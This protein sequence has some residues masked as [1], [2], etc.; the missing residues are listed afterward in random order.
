MKPKP[1][2]INT[3]PLSCMAFWFAVEEV[4]MENGCLWV[5][6]GSH[7]GCRAAFNLEIPQMKSQRVL[8]PV[9]RGTKKQLELS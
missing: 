6:P 7:K 4:T 9:S 2:F 1:K 3:K 8:Q 5:A